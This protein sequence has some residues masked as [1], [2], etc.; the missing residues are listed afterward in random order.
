MRPERRAHPRRPVRHA[1]RIALAAHS[2]SGRLED[3]GRWQECLIEDISPGGAK[4]TVQALHELGADVHLEIG[5]FGRFAA[6]IA[7]RG[8]KE[9]GLRFTDGPER[10]GE[11]VLGLAVYG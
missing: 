10:M 3:H 9:L 11:V 4:I 2:L 5:R 8:E 6:Q 7:W 1:A